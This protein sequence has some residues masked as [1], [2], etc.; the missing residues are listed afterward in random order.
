[1]S[2]LQNEFLEFIKPVFKNNGSDYESLLKKP[3]GDE[4]DKMQILCHF[5]YFICMPDKMLFEKS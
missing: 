3:L 2:L 4:S 5:Y 1:M